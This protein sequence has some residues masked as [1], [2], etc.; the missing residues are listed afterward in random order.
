MTA[1]VTGAA[2]FDPAA[3]AAYLSTAL[4]QEDAHLSL[5]RISG[6]QSNPTYFVD[7]GPRRFVLRK[8]PNGPLLKGAH[9]ID[10]EYRVLSALSATPVPV[11]APVLFCDDGSVIGTSFYLMERVEGRVLT[12]C[13]LPGM[14]PQ[15]RRAIY[16]SMADALAALHSVKAEAVGLG[17]FGRPGDY[18]ARQFR[19][20]GGQLDASPSERIEELHELSAWLAANMPEDDGVV[21]VVHGDFRLGNMLFHPTEPRVVAVLDWELSTLGHPLADLGFCCMPWHTS[22]DEYGGILGTDALETGVPTKAEF[23]AHYAGQMPGLAPLQPFHAAFALFRFAVIFVGIADRAAAG[24]A[25]D[26]NAA[27]LAPLARRFAIRALE[28]IRGQQ[29]A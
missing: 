7:W 23:V 8:Q 28:I 2:D 20:W 18:F 19:R 17:D 29:K 25:S 27:N 21:S 1:V 10:R 9:A 16:F 4:P 26:A 3:L 5:E 24:T 6:G 22:P 13:T 15:E 12:D 14:T 11:P